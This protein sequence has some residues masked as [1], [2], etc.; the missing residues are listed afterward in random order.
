MGPAGVERDLGVARRRRPLL[1]LL[2]FGILCSC[3]LFLWLTADGVVTE[4]HD[5]RVA[6]R[7]VVVSQRRH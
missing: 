2:L 5:R 1:L 4:R 3:S 6:A 7:V